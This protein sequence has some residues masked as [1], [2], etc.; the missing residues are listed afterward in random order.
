MPWNGMAISLPAK[1]GLLYLG[2]ES[3]QEIRSRH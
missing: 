2:L 1:R 3:L